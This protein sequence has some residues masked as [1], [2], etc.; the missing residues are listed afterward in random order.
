MQHSAT[1]VPTCGSTGHELELS[2]DC[3]T[4]SSPFGCLGLL[5]KEGILAFTAAGVYEV[6]SFRQIHVF[7]K[8]QH[9][10]FLQRLC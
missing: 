1:G 4:S 10:F 2:T 8:S 5:Q 9:K 6:D 3:G 7:N